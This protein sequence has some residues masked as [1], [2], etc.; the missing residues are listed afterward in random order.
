[1]KTKVI[2]RRQGKASQQGA[3]QKQQPQAKPKEPAAKSPSKGSSFALVFGGKKVV[4]QARTGT[5][6]EGTFKEYRDGAFW[7]EDVVI[8]G[9]NFE[10]RVEHLAVDRTIFAHLHTLP[11]ELKEKSKEE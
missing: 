11:V 2:V 3:Q 1:M 10:A 4:L 5:I 6:Y 8:K 7:M 9:Q